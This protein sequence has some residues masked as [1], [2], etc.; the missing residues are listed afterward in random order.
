MSKS[1]VIIANE[2]FHQGID[3][4]YEKELQFGGGRK[5][6]PDFTI[7]DAASGLTVYWEHCGM[8]LDAGY[9]AFIH[10]ALQRF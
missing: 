9:L 5:C 8:L 6:K 2:L 7:E 3:Y 1:E 4:A 10:I